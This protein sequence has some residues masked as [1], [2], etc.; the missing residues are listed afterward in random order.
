MRGEYVATGDLPHH[1]SRFIPTCVGNTPSTTS[2]AACNAVH[3]HMRGEYT[4]HDAGQQ[5][6]L[7]SSPHAW[8]ILGAYSTSMQ[9]TRFIPTCVG[10]TAT[11]WLSPACSAVHPHM[12]GEYQ[13]FSASLVVELGSSPHAW[14]IL[15]AACLHDSS[16]RF[17]PTCVGNTLSSTTNAPASSVHPHMRGEYEQCHRVA[18]LHE[19]FI[20]TCVGNTS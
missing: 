13:F 12:R 17:I 10:N 2:P 1:P 3:P 15:A 19:R 16:F 9:P 5:R 18:G 14:G 8:G 20:P 7:G 4:G 11:G 6:V